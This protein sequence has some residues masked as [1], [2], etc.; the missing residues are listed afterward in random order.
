MSA[1]QR[2]MPRSVRL[3]D[4][5]SLSSVKPLPRSFDSVS[6]P[7]PEYLRPNRTPPPASSFASCESPP[8]SFTSPVYRSRYS[9]PPSTDLSALE[10]FLEEFDD[11]IGLSREEHIVMREE[12][13]ALQAERLEQQSL[14][15]RKK[16]SFLKIFARIWNVAR[17]EWL[18]G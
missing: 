2:A 4:S 9:P 6:A 8:V 3:F 18:I 10:Y 12:R 1:G 15:A 17:K 5:G 7:L 11:A 14:Y 16:P 13:N